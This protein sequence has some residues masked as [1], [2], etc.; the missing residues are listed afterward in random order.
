MQNAFSYNYG[1]SNAFF[2]YLFS[3]S[4]HVGGRPTILLL[5]AV[6]LSASDAARI[7]PAMFTIYFDEI[8]KW[9]TKRSEFVSFP[10]KHDFHTNDLW[11]N[12]PMALLFGSRIYYAFKEYWLYAISFSFLEKIVFL[13]RAEEN[14][15]FW[16]NRNWIGK[17][18]IFCVCVFS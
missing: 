13:L 5:S 9:I 7:T 6:S 15:Q 1:I 2:F 4:V 8:L 3:I 18:F 12:S 14:C 10:S 11:E 16:W 17:E